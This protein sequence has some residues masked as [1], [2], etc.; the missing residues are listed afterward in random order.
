MPVKPSGG[1]GKRESYKTSV[2]RVPDPIKPQ[3]LKLIEEFHQQRSTS[4]VPKPVTSTYQIPVFVVAEFLAVDDILVENM[5]EGAILHLCD[6]PRNDWDERW[7]DQWERFA[8]PQLELFNQLADRVNCCLWQIDNTFAI[9][10]PTDDYAAFNRLIEYR[11]M[12]RM[13]YAP[14]TARQ[15]IDWSM[16]LAFH[17]NELTDVAQVAIKQK[18]WDILSAL[19]IG[20]EPP[21]ERQDYWHKTYKE[22]LAKTRVNYWK[23]Q[24]NPESREICPELTNLLTLPKPTVHAA[25]VLEFLADKRDPF[26]ESKTTV[27]R[28]A[29]HW[30]EGGK[31]GNCKPE[32]KRAYRQ[33]FT[34]WHLS[35]VA[36]LGEDALKRIYKVV[37]GCG[38]TLIED[39]ISPM[40]GQWWEVLDVSPNASVQEV[41]AAHR[42]LAK[43]WHPD[44][45]PSPSARERMSKINL[46]VEEFEKTHS[47]VR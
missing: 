32:E 37:Y 13:N 2:T 42:R 1:R 14:A 12:Q 8:R 10:E 19:E 40:L 39:I 31:M 7:D 24:D 18:R 41:K 46:A 44:V 28:N 38:W 3:V 43:I 36:Q 4:H 30:E 45:N 26:L 34:R 47:L 11:L 6:Y 17:L 25:K 27:K 29:L 33:A 20:K 9:A 16:K 21:V 23:W 22:L 35:A 5:G 15:V